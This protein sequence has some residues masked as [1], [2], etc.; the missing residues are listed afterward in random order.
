MNLAY[1]LF[2]RHGILPSRTAEMGETELALLA[3]MLEM[4]AEG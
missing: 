1:R 4:E 3:A 2:C